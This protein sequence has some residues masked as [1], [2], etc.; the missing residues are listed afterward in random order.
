MINVNVRTTAFLTR[1]FLP[2]PLSR[3][4][5]SLVVFLSSMAA[6]IKAPYSVLY[7]ATKSFITGFA[8]A[9]KIEMRDRLDVCCISPGGVNTS[10]HPTQLKFFMFDIGNV[11]VA[12]KQSIGC[13]AH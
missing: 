9:I 12:A 8:H 1:A 11:N 10:M 13:F 5:H 4:H 7:N 2:H 6:D 3:S